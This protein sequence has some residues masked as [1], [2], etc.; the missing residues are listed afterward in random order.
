MWVSCDVAA[1]QT[2]FSGVLLPLLPIRILGKLQVVITVTIV[3]RVVAPLLKGL[4]GDGLR[5][6]VLLVGGLA[7]L[8]VG[9]VED[10]RLPLATYVAP[11]VAPGPPSATPSP[12]GRE[13]PPSAPAPASGGAH[14]CSSGCVATP[15]AAG[16][17]PAC[18][19]RGWA[20]SAGAVSPGPHGVA[21]VVTVVRV[22]VTTAVVMVVVPVVVV[23][24][25][26]VP[27]VVRGVGVASPPTTAPPTPRGRHTGWG[28]VVVVIIPVHPHTH[29]HTTQH[30]GLQQKDTPT[31]HLH[32][33]HLTHEPLLSANHLSLPFFWYILLLP[34]HAFMTPLTVLTL[35]FWSS[36]F[37]PGVLSSSCLEAWPAQSQS[38]P[39]PALYRSSHPS[40]DDKKIK[41]K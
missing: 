39:H 6:P 19:G 38:P 23:I 34:F 5:P 27:V 30:R 13:G 2:P 32:S 3:T 1:A 31:K 9:L 15:A 8:G 29:T 16:W 17:R 11:A 18:S 21:V 4:L 40:P 22:V 10:I 36:V 26:I 7:V 41:N 28:V 37:E 25:I 12:L 24:V 33:T 35:C 20:A 14:G